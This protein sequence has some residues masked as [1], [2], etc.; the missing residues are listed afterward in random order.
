MKIVTYPAQNPFLLVRQKK[1]VKTVNG[2]RQ[3]APPLVFCL[4]LVETETGV[5]PRFFETERVQ[6]PV[7]KLGFINSIIKF[8]FCFHIPEK[9]RATEAEKVGYFHEWLR[10]TIFTG[11]RPFLPFLAKKR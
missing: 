7:L 3:T 8:G 6:I 10:L 1:A 11:F 5:S 4:I 2:K 9:V